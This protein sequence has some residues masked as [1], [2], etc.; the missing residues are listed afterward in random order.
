VVQ[1]ELCQDTIAVIDTDKQKVLIPSAGHNRE[2]SCLVKIGLSC[3]FRR[4]SSCA[5][6]LIWLIVSCVCREPVIGIGCG[7]YSAGDRS[8]LGG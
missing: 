1:H 4:D 8:G 5:A 3:L 6:P 7:C 2:F